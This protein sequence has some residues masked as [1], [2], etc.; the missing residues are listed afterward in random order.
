MQNFQDNF[1]LERLASGKLIVAR[2]NVLDCFA[3]SGHHKHA[4]SVEAVGAYVDPHI[5]TKEMS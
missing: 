5:S 1:K 4:T 3:I 2:T